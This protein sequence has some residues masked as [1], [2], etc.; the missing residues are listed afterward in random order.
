MRGKESCEGCKQSEGHLRKGW[1]HCQV[2]QSLGK[3]S[4]NVIGFESVRSGH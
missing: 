3:Q 1:S 2:Q 4:G